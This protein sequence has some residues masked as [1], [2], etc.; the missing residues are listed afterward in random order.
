MPTKRRKISY[1]RPQW[2]NDPNITLQDALDICLARLPTVHDTRLSLGT[3]EAAIRH[4][5]VR[6]NAMYLHIA[7][8]TPDEATSTVP[9]SIGQGADEDLASAPAGPNWTISMAMERF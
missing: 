7:S 5:N 8:W 9:H 2:I 3:G 6:A 1:M 4:R